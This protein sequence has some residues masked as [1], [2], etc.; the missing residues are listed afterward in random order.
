MTVFRALRHPRVVVARR[1]LAAVLAVA[2]LQIALGIY[3]W[4]PVREVHLGIL[5]PSWESVA[6]VALLIAMS[7]RT[8]PRWT[9]RTVYIL[10]TVIV[11]GFALLGFGQ[12]LARLEFNQD[13]VVALQLKYVPALFSMM[14]S[15]QSLA[16]YLIDL[17]VMIIVVVAAVAAI[18]LS[19]RHLHRLSTH[20]G[21]R[22]RLAVGFA[23]ATVVLSLV[24]GLRGPLAGVAAEQIDF[25]VH[26]SHRIKVLARKLEREAAEAHASGSLEVGSWKPDVM[27]FVIEA[28]GAVLYRHEHPELAGFDRFLDGE[29]DEL[30]R[31]G[32][33]ARSRFLTSPIF[34][35]GSWMANATILCGVTINSQ[36]RFGGLLASNLDCLPAVL[37]RAGY[38]T[39]MA[40]ANT[41]YALDPGYLRRAPFSRVYM[42][43][44][45]G[46]RGARMSWSYM[47]DQYVIHWVDRHE[48]APRTGG[49]LLTYTILTS[50]HHPWN[51]IPPYIDDWSSLGDGTIYHRVPSILFPD[52]RFVTGRHYSQGYE[53]SIEYV[54]HTIF[55]YVESLPPDRERI[56]V[57]VGDHE[58]HRPVANESK[59]PWWVPVHVLSRDPAAVERFASLGY[60]PGLV[61]DIKTGAGP[62][63]RL[64]DHLIVALSGGGPPAAL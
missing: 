48:V 47:P 12:G 55:K 54:L 30:V 63:K 17:A 52:N 58:P 60:V 56:I 45:F 27:V 9:E 46:Y 14:R 61:P 44:D 3:Y 43:D 19:I 59:D 26:K 31:A 20:P 18:Y 39:I 25:A 24:V 21:R 40:A 41:T 7:A 32:Y 64:F 22:A 34:G 53:A 33:H 5:A 37:D 4:L 51:K 29:H 50:S 42:R 28:Y 49:P 38:R 36:K 35:G 11:V 1:V 62:L 16:W 10:L 6:L 8:W 15:T 23:A 57:I 2:A 13:L